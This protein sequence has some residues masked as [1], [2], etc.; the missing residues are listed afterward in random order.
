VGCLL[1]SGDALTLLAGR[2]W[3]NAVDGRRLKIVK[4]ALLRLSLN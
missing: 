1:K 3:V 2:V 4:S